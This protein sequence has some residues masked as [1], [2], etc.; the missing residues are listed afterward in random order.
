M[1]LISGTSNPLLA[2]AIA[3]QLKIPLVETEISTFANG[4]K[5]VWIKEKLDG[6][7]VTVVQSFSDPVDSSIIECLL[8]IDALERLGAK[9]VHLVIPWMGYS[10]QDKV[11]RDG[12]PIAAK[13]IAS[14]IS[15]SYVK[16]VFVVDLHNT[17]ITGFF[18]VPSSHIT[19]MQLFADYVHANHGTKNTV[20]AAPDFGGMK[21]ARQFAALLDVNL[22][23][24]D[25]IRDLKSGD[26]T[27][28]GLHGDV[29]DKTVIIYDD[30]I[31]GGSTV[32]ETADL[33][34][35][36]GAVAVHFYATHG[37]FVGNAFERIMNSSVDSVLVTNSVAHVQLPSKIK[38]ID[39]SPVV[40]QVLNQWF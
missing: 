40:A 26:V 19:A 17:S 36:E 1:K 9:D 18:N 5:R 2:S 4:E 32:A 37:L 20:V 16:R 27:A 29:S 35:R 39:L 22:V 28:V 6:Q 33:L 23:N 3:H 21:R 34:K 11:F 10:L 24:I 13:M 14:I 8:V 30:I 7:D 25:K 38:T 12:E 31:V 15:H